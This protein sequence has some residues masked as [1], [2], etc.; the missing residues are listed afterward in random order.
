MLAT[1]SA[2][3]CVPSDT[4]VY[5]FYYTYLQKLLQ[6]LAIKILKLEISLLVDILLY[7]MVGEFELLSQA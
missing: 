3:V 2:Q 7:N 4:V 5:I 6:K 1:A